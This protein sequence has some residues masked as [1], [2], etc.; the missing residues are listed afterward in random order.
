MLPSFLLSLLFFDS[1]LVIFLLLC[2]T[3]GMNEL[4]IEYFL[5][6]AENNSFSKTAAEK[7]VSQPSISKQISLL[8]EELGVK[9]F[10]RGHKS[11]QLTGAGLLFA[12]YYKNCSAEFEK[13]SHLAKNIQKQGGAVFRIASGQSWPLNDI[14]P[15][16]TELIRKAFPHVSIIME[17][18]GFED[19]ENVLLDD[20]ADVVISPTIAIRDLHAVEKRHF[21]E[22]RHLII[23]SG[24]HSL[25]KRKNLSAK[26]FQNEVFFF[27]A[28]IDTSFAQN[29]AKTYIEPHGF[30]PKFQSVKNDQSM[31]SNVLNGFGVAM[32]DTWFFQAYQHVL[33]AIQLDAYTS[34]VLAWKRGN[35][36][37]ML[38]LFLREIKAPS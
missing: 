7:Y 25:A 21:T 23:Y 20:S 11:S 38:E 8:E 35:Q 28:G 24:Q 37:P 9:L 34:I 13:V 17:N 1:F 3:S 15:S 4:Q 19:L 31:I 12:E 14:L 2:Y 16:A 5:A 22:L 27:P 18:V 32:V 29:L 10:I 36:K 26:D 33:K 6:I 30:M